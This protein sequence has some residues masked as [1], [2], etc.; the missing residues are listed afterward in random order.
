MQPLPR[1]RWLVEPK[2]AVA[3]VTAG[4]LGAGVAMAAP[5]VET[6]ET[7]PAALSVQD[8]PDGDGLVEDTTTPEAQEPGTVLPD[9]PSVEI[10]GDADTGEPETSTEILPPEETDGDAV[11][12]P[13]E[14]PTGERST[15][16]QSR[17]SPV[18]DAVHEVHARRDELRAEGG[19]RAFGQAVAA[20]AR[21]ANG[22]ADR[23]PDQDEDDDLDDPEPSTSEAR[24]EASR[25]RGGPPDG[26]P[27]G[28][29]AGRGNDRR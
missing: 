22:S 17:R 1:L 25:G 4:M 3:V 28:P 18:A 20:A 23:S 16:E 29:P 12:D 15:N 9:G 13:A 8:T 26:V 10:D 14:D 27:P 11:Q 6:I 19:G 24:P 5:R 7:R 21:A 2:V